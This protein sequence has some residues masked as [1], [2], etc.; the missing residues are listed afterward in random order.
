MVKYSELRGKQSFGT[1]RKY[2][3]GGLRNVL[4]NGGTTP[5]E[6]KNKSTT[7]R[8]DWV[9]VS[10][11]VVGKGHCLQSNNFPLVLFNSYF[12]SPSLLLLAN[13]SLYGHILL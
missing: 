6:E 12:H 10:F 8:V 3:F 2:L 13:L 9:R 5:G 11:E 7:D 4:I 1:P